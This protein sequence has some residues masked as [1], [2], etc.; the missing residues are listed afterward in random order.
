MATAYL[1]R[2][3]IPKNIETIPTNK[4]INTPKADKNMRVFI[5]SGLKDVLP[6]VL[7]LSKK[8]T[9]SNN[10]IFYV[11]LALKRWLEQTF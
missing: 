11:T 1:L 4:Y 2:C 7:A 3:T 5:N 10:I 8:P 6:R 9:I